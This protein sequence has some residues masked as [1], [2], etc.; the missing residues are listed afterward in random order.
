MTPM[1][2]LTVALLLACGLVACNRKGPELP[3]DVKATADAANSEGV[4][5]VVV[6]P[7]AAFVGAAVDGAGE[8][9]QPQREFKSGETVYISVPSK[10]R[11]LGSSVE[12]FWFHDDG[13]SRKDETKRIEGPFTVFEFAPKDA[14][15]YNT[16]VDVN[17]RPIALVEFEV[18]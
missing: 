18:K 16:E 17:G 7:N 14:G 2:R 13:R 6:D 10:G 5:P 9:T 1:Q 8:I 4:E 15:K 3:T 12:I 11:Q